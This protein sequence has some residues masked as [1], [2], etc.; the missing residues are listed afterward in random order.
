MLFARKPSSICC[1]RVCSKKRRDPF[2]SRQRTIIPNRFVK[3]IF[4]KLNFKKMKINKKLN[5]FFNKV[6]S[7]GKDGRPL[8]SLFYTTNAQF[9]QLLYVRL[10]NFFQTSTRS[11]NIVFCNIWVKSIKIHLSE[12]MT[13]KNFK[14]NCKTCFHVI[15]C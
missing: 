9:Y 1:H 6:A 14:Y 3:Y 7:F 13:I 15:S 2:W 12:T 8:N 4:L 10:F 11:E 5:F